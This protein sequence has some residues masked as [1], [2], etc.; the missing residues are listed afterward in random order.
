MSVELLCAQWVVPVEPDSVVLTDHTVAIED[1]RILAIEPTGRAQQRWPDAPRTLLPGQMLLPGL[2]NLHSHAAMSLLRGAADDLPLQQWLAD[3]IWPI[4]GKLMSPEFVFDGALL[5]AYEMLRGG[6][7]CFK[8][9]SRRKR[10]H[11]RI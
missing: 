9:P 2:V 6:I 7:T 3:R 11:P 4:E 8:R 10:E 5:A 1:G